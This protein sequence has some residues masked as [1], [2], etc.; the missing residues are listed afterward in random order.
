[1]KTAVATGGLILFLVA[2][3]ARPSSLPAAPERRPETPARIEAP[4]VVTLPEPVPAAPE[5]SRPAPET[6]PAALPAPAGK[7]IAVQ[8]VLLL[9][10]ERELGLSPEQRRHVEEAMLQRQAEVAAYQ[11]EIRRTRVLREREYDRRIR[12][13]M[14]AS[15][16]RMSQVFGSAQNRR[17]MDLL[18]DG[19]LSDGVEFELDPDI[20]IVP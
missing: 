2:F 14:G 20:V 15:Y 18:A 7:L 3:A 16:A 17:F 6:A 4:L 1:M 8:Q 11:D 5:P 12:E 19:R 9:C 10:T 13:I